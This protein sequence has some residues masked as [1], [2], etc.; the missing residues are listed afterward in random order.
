MLFILMFFNKLGSYDFCSFKARVLQCN[1]EKNRNT[2]LAY[3]IITLHTMDGQN[4]YL[5]ILVVDQRM[6]LLTPSLHVFGNFSLIYPMASFISIK[7]HLSLLVSRIMKK[8]CRFFQTF[9]FHTIKE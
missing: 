6:L 2:K 3:R 9:I 8:K 1:N 4:L 5:Y 7:V